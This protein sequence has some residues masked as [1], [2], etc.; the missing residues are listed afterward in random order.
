MLLVGLIVPIPTYL[1]HKRFPRAGFEHV[2]TPVVV[3]ELGFLSVGINS[4]WMTS[5]AVAVFSQWY[6]RKY[7]GQSP[8]HADCMSEKLTTCTA[9]WFRK[10]NFLLSAA[11][12]GGT[13]VISAVK[14]IKMWA[15][16]D[17]LL[18]L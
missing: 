18:R 15:F 10:Y 6:L 9:K 17:S 4:S 5:L 7:R 11:L 8:R 13:Q 12:D 2:F 3:A 16:A 1:L 14:V